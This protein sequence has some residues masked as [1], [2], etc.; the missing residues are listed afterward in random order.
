M[1]KATLP[2]NKIENV[3]TSFLQPQF[4]I[5]LTF[6]K[7][8]VF[9]LTFKQK[10]SQSEL[11]MWKESQIIL[12]DSFLSVLLRLFGIIDRVTEW[13]SKMVRNFPNDQVRAGENKGESS[14][15]VHQL[16]G[17]LPTDLV[18]EN[19]GMYTQEVRYYI[20]YL[21]VLCCVLRWIWG[22]W[23]YYERHTGQAEKYAW[24]RVWFPLFTLFGTPV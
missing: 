16:C 4:Q 1:R 18:S 2:D 23:C 22:L 21:R 7:D 13:L 8:K 17:W 20:V 10:S 3:P 19:T 15:V 5:K 24:P 11:K 14:G 6:S 9:K 12:N